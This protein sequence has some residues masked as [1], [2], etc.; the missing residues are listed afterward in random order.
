MK[1]FFTSLKDKIKKWGF[2]DSDDEF[3]EE[4]LEL[5]T[6]SKKPVSSK[7]I[8]RPFILEDFSDIKPVLDSLR[9]GAT[10]CLI[11]IRPLKD[12]DLVELKRAINKLKKT[13]D[14]S[15]G[16]IAGFGDDYLVATP[17]FAEIYRTKEPENKEL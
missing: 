11:N 12:K 3:E 2:E 16:D 8:V 7:V 1:K 17:G 9:E 5:D 15:G 13:C 10:V 4:Y 14:A 6:T